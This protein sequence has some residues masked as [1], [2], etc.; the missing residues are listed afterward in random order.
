MS[1]PTKTTFCV[2]YTMFFVNVLFWLI[3]CII[4][5]ISSFAMVN[6]KELY[7]KINNLATDPAVMLAIAGVLMFVI[8]F[9][10]C[11]GALRENVCMLRFYSIMLGIMLLL[12]I[13]AAVLGY[14]Y[15]GEVKQ[16]VEKAVDHIIVRYRDDPDLQNIIDLLQKELKCC[17][18]KD[19]KT[20][21]QNVYFNCSSPSVERCGVPFSCCISDQINSQCGFGAIRM[22]ESQASKVIY[23]KGCI[24]GAESWFMTNLIMMASIAASLPATQILGYCLARRLIED[25]RDIIR[26]QQQAWG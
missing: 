16:Q 26:R 13:V 9:S 23:T 7:G 1:Y 2:K 12:E 5:A 24:Q 20:W 10:G 11:L 14:V 22:S 3:S 18:S 8:S 19:Y 4:L 21:E 15:A 6:K 25:I 17:G